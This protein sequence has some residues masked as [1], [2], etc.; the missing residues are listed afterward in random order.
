M[1]AASGVSALDLVQGK[2]IHACD[3]GPS[4]KIA[5][6]GCCEKM[7]PRDEMWSMNTKFMSPY[8]QKEIR[9]RVRLCPDCA[10]E[11]MAD[12]KD[13]EWDNDSMKVVPA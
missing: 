5:P 6:C 13:M 4:R 9:L 3:A 8:D 2:E 12:V 1:S 7:V 11:Q 10:A